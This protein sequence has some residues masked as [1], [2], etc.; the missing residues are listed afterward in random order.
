MERWKRNMWVLWIGVFFTSASYT[1]VIPFLPLFLLQIGVHQHTEIWAG[2]L[3]SAAFLAGAISSPYWGMLADKYGRKPMIIRAGFSLFVIYTLT[4]FVNNPYELLLLRIMQGL[5]TGF[6][7]GAIALIGTNTPK[8]N[9]GYALAMI[10]T[11]TASGGIIGPLLGGGISTLVGNRWSFAS[12]GLL[13][14][15]S[16]ILVIYMVTEDNFTPCTTRGS[17]INDIR[18]ARANRPF[19]L[20]LLLTMVTVCSLMTIEPVL[21]LYI[22]KLGGSVENI[23]F[24]AG[25]IFSLPGIASILFGAF[26]GRLADKIGFRTI[27]I[28]GLCGGGIGTVAQILFHDIWGFSIIRFIFGIFF[29]AVFPALNGLVVKLTPDDF[30]G[31]AFGLNQTAN[32]I[33]GM[34]GPVLGGFI[35]GIFTIHT[36]FLITGIFLLIAMAIAWK[37]NWKNTSTKRHEKFR[38]T[39]TSV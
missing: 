16:T 34:L 6:I 18:T 29:C 5:L 35:G 21:P 3:F 25:V 24:L 37:S 32:Q 30:R 14:L 1:M 33:G 13:V 4:A 31:R 23:S 17:V 11:A 8:K 15:L 39:S 22:K 38:S 26:W 2:V 36:V 20:V 28:I 27:L 7:P 9:V 10:S 19:M 12:G